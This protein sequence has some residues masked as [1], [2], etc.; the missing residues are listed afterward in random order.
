MKVKK[1]LIFTD[2]SFP[3]GMAATN[4]IIS[5][6]KGFIHNGVDCNVICFRKTENKEKYVNVSVKGVYEGIKFD[7]LSSS[8]LKSEYFI[9][10]RLDLI[11]SN[12]RLLGFSLGKIDKSTL[13]IYYSS[14]TSSAILIWLAN[15]LKGGKFVKEQ[16]EHPLVYID[17]R[18]FLSKILYKTFHFKLFDANLLMTKKLIEYYNGI[19]DTPNL[20]VPMTVALK[21]FNPDLRNHT[22]H[23]HKILYTG[24]LD[25]NKDGVD[26]LLEAF[27]EVVKKHE[28][29]HLYLYG[30]ANS[31]EGLKKYH[32]L[33]KDFDMAA[34]V[35]FKGLVTRDVITKKV[36][37]ANILVLPRPDSLQ[38]QNGFPTKL[39]E[40]LASGNPTLVTSVGEIPNY[41][42]DKE[43]TFM[44]T[45]GDVLSLKKKL[46]E[47]IENY[48]FAQ[49]V[50]LNGRKTAETHFN[51]IN[52]TK[53]II[54]YFN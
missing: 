35:H 52:Q 49:K 12:L 40:Y 42:K 15:K 51:N 28:T 44:A 38:A 43:N 41:L 48:D 1:V 6:A 19:S 53:S 22:P 24:Q 27:A 9:K 50:G 7:Y 11:Y 26:V 29:Y 30:P 16:S 2:E 5:Y 18:N 46:F 34:N 39:G 10:R 23:K 4:R 45:P 37:N 32:D 54:N 33:V 36:L 47:I 20:H 31:E 3:H 14:H 17:N 13:S 25:D 8:T 21:R